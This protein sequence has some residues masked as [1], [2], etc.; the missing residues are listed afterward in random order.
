MSPMIVGSAGVG[1]LLLAFVLNL[2]RMLSERHPAYLTMNVLG[3]GL[4]AWYAWVGGVVPFVV[5]ESVW[6]GVALIR[7][8]GVV[9]GK[10]E[11]SP[12]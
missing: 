9:A 10:K 4:A 6:G 12:S 1:L 3:A 11:G 5:I 7:L 8:M 2:L